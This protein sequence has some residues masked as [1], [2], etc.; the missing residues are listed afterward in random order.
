MRQ[1]NELPLIFLL[2]TLLFLGCGSGSK[3]KEPKSIPRP[4][5][6][7]L[8]KKSDP[9]LLTRVTGSVES[10][11]VEKVGFEVTGRILY[12]VERG[13][14][15]SGNIYDDNGEVLTNG[16][17]I[18]E[19]QDERHTLRLKEAKARVAARQADLVRR[20]KEYKRQANLLAKGATSQ[21]KYEKAESEFRVAGARLREAE[22]LARQTEVDLRDT[23]LYSPFHG[24]VSKVH[25]IPGAYVERGQPVVSVQMMDPVKVE[26]AVSPRTDRQ[27]NYG[28]MLKVYIEGNK[29][30]LEGTVWFKGSVADAATRTFMV[31][32]LVRNRLIEVGVPEDLKGTSF[33]RTNDIMKVEMDDYDGQTIYLAEQSSIHRDNEGHFLWKVEG[34]S[35][36]DLY[37]DF[38]PVFTVRKVRIKLGKR[39]IR[40]LQSYT[41]REI[42][43][44]GGLNPESDLVTGT[45]SDTPKEGETVFFS[46]KQWLMRPG[47]LV[48]VDTTGGKV[49]G[50]F[51]VPVQAII[52]D[53]GGQYVFLVKEEGTGDERA[54]KVEVIASASLDNFRRIEPH[55]GQVLKEGM[56]LIVS[57]AHYLGD[58]DLINA[59]DEV[60]VS[61]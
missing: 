2:T 24:Q 3:D 7:M 51:Y 43:D 60:E 58:G 16:T 34:L 13:V 30:P 17:V 44:L 27:I 31:T 53:D 14:E 21:K 32:L 23:R 61:P 54:Q 56:K 28:D 48:H 46:R 42:E 5:A 57:G 4:V 12:V 1:R 22:R 36:A 40:L 29:T 50:G 11:K 39:V 9:I 49:T 19:L 10:W 59:F 47:E 55:Q 26:I 38:N 52:E 41:Y 25:V 18:A 37:T 15:I 35:A 33:H 20:D 8:L 45:I 6:Y